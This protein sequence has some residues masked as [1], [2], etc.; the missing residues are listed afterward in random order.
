MAF[1]TAFDHTPALCQKDSELTGSQLQV[2]LRTG[3][4]DGRAEKRGRSRVA[5]GTQEERRRKDERV[6]G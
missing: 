5:E 1:R 6:H 3:D 4:R 2:I